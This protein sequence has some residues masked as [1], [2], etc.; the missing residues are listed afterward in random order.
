MRLNVL[1]P[2]SWKTPGYSNRSDRRRRRNNWMSRAQARLPDLRKAVSSESC[3]GSVKGTDRL[4]P[5]ALTDESKP[6]DPGAGSAAKS[7]ISDHEMKRISRRRYQLCWISD[8][9]PRP[10]VQARPLGPAAQPESELCLNL[11]RLGPNLHNNLPIKQIF[12]NWQLSG[13][14]GFAIRNFLFDIRY[15]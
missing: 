5:S 2:K 7:M 10:R 1:S 13:I 3:T 15:S 12:D 8:G 11:P 9:Y 6:L 14:A 4:L